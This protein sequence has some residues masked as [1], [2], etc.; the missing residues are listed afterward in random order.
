M[1]KYIYSDIILEKEFSF[2]KIEN[3]LRGFI[4]FDYTNLTI[5]INWYLKDNVLY[6]NLISINDLSGYYPCIGYTGIKKLNGKIISGKIY[7]VG[8]SKEPNEDTT[9]PIIK[10]PNS[11]IEY[12]LILKTWTKIF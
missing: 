6:G 4:D 11:I 2:F 5:E 12:S 1:K 10:E 7:C 9:I 3:P 8:F